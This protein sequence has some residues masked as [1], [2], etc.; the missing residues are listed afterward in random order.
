[1]LSACLSISHGYTS[2]S[3]ACARCIARPTHS[4]T[5]PLLAAATGSLQ[6]FNQQQT[7]ARP[8]GSGGIPLA[9][10]T[11][12]MRQ[13]AGASPPTIQ[14]PVYSRPLR[15]STS[16]NLP[17]E[18]HEP[19]ANSPPQIRHHPHSAWPACFPSS[20]RNFGFLRTKKSRP[21]NGLTLPTVAAVDV[22][23]KPQW[24][25]IYTRQTLLLYVP[26]CHLDPLYS[27]PTYD[28]RL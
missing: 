28:T 12:H 22:S 9:H 3:H 25:C 19:A 5:G 21:R 23:S 27:P 4:P 10:R 11:F 16:A 13:H 18:F 15:P 1:M 14:P 8:R 20:P 24:Y 6:A 26:Y 17:W 2:E 7:S